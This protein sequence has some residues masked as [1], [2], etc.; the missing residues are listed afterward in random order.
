VSFLRFA[1]RAAAGAGGCFVPHFAERPANLLI[2]SHLGWGSGEP[3]AGPVARE[4]GRLAPARW[5]LADTRSE[6][7]R[8]PISPW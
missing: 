6:L 5:K 4:Q 7:M 2:G 3:I 1:R 8:G